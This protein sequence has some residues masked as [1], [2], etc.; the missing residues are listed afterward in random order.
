MYSLTKKQGKICNVFPA[1]LLLEQERLPG[2]RNV[3]LTDR[4]K[5]E[6]NHPKGWFSTCM[7]NSRPRRGTYMLHRLGAALIGNSDAVIQR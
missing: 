5:Q 1:L 3:L 2:E 4:P 6:E 7:L